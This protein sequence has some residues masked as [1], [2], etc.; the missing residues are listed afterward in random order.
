METIRNAKRWSSEK[1]EVRFFIETIDDSGKVHHY[2]RYLT[3]NRWHQP[4]T[5]GTEKM[6]YGME[7]GEPGAE[8][9][10]E[11]KRLTDNGQHSYVQPQP[12]R[13]ED[14]EDIRDEIAESRTHRP[15]DGRTDFEEQTTF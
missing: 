12:L 9:I 5:W 14:Q 11:Y 8:V 6:I 10:A 4:R 1:K 3:G 7:E 13:G 15:S 2:T